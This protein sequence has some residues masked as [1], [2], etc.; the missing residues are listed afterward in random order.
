[1]KTLTK[2]QKQ[3]QF[4]Q[5]RRE[6]RLDKII[7]GGEPEAQK[8]VTNA[9]N[10]LTTLLDKQ[11][12]VEQQYAATMETKRL[13]D[14]WQ[15]DAVSRLKDMDLKAREAGVTDMDSV[16]QSSKSPTKGGEKRQ[17]LVREKKIQEQLLLSTKKKLGM[18]LAQKKRDLEKTK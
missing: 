10:I 3:L 7:I 8:D 2:E 16:S 5:T 4:E 14:K 12:K 6:K 18:E 15:A 1:M 13:Q 11:S 9:Q 17:K